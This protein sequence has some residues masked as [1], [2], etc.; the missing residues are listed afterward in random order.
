MSISFPRAMP[1]D[2]IADQVFEPAPN[3]YASPE[4]SGRIGG[5]QAGFPMWSALWSIAQSIGA[6]KSDEVQA[7]LASL[8]GNKQLFYGAD[9]TRPLPKLYPNGFGG[10]TRYGGGSF[11]G[12]ASS[13]SVSTDGAVVTLNGLPAGLALSLK[14][15]IGFTWTTGSAARRGL[16]RC[17]EAV[18][19]NGSGVA[20]VTVRPA[21]SPAIPGTAVATLDHPT[22]LMRLDVTQTKLAPMGRRLAISGTIAAVQQLLP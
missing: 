8:D 22:C 10:L 18:T 19:A 17:V 13:W 12:T 14:D 5:V 4:N 21:L 2:F 7:W 11:D 1:A 9:P 6:A 3:D 20:V 15:Y 16:A